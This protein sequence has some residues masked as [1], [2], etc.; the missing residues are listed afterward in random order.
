M[1]FFLFSSYRSFIVSGEGY[2]PREEE[3][4]LVRS[5]AAAGYSEEVHLPEEDYW[6][7]AYTWTEGRL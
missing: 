3:P 1:L 7:A 6:A 5:E 2:F 4:A